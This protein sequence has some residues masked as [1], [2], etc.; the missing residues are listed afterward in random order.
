MH[1]SKLLD[2]KGRAASEF[3]AFVQHNEGLRRGL[4]PA[5]LDIGSLRNVQAPSAGRGSLRGLSAEG[6]ASPTPSI[7]AA[8]GSEAGAEAMESAST[9]SKQGSLAV[10][11]WWEF[12]EDSQGQVLVKPSVRCIKWINAEVDGLGEV[13]VAAE[14]YAVLVLDVPDE[15]RD[16]LLPARVASSLAAI[17]ERVQQSLFSRSGGARP[18]PAGGG[19]APSAVSRA[20]SR[21]ESSFP[22]EEEGSDLVEEAF[23]AVYPET[24]QEVV[25]VKDFRDVTRALYRWDNAAKRLDAL[26]AR[27]GAK[28]PGKGA[29]IEVRLGFL[30]LWG[31]K[32]PAVAYYEQLVE[33][34]AE[35]V[36][37]ARREARRG[38]PSPARFVLFSSQ[39]AAA[40][41]AQSCLMPVDSTRFRVVK[42]P[43][44]DDIYWPS[45]QMGRRE[46]SL[47]Q[48]AVIPIILLIMTLP[49]GIFAG[50]V[51]IFTLALCGGSDAI[52]S[53]IYWPWFCESTSAFNRLIKT[54]LV[55][56]L[57]PLLLTLWQIVVMR[58]LYYV[59]SAEGRCVS[60]SG[61]DRRILKLYF[62][63]D[64]FNLFLGATCGS[65]L[66][67][68]GSQAAR[69]EI[70]EIFAFLGPALNGASNFFVSYVSLRAFTM[71]PFK[72]LYPH[73]AVLFWSVRKLVGKMCCCVGRCDATFRQ[74]FESWAPKSFMY[75][76]E[77]GIFLLI[78]L[79]GIVYAVSTPILPAFCALY[80]L[81][82]W[83]V[84]KHH[85]LYVYSRAYESGGYYYYCLFNRVLI[86]LNT[87][88]IFTS[89]QFFSKQAWVQAVVLIVTGPALVASFQQLLN[90]RVGRVIENMP[91]QIAA[92]MPAG[93]V[94]R[95]LYLPPELRRES[96]G[97]HPESGKAW[98]GYGVP[99]WTL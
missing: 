72:L 70:K 74:Q 91:L 93:R 44:P 2:S 7:L 49:A 94:P 20:L 30:G 60:L 26:R 58:V 85:L 87:M 14:F 83:G 32:V 16:R 57:P 40:T 34:Y 65:S 78:L 75:G 42:A 5:A 46:K 38:P 79:I 97:W 54:V 76:K 17:P 35:E 92:T 51:S 27:Q 80:F 50:A 18:G 21:T 23:Q 67:L 47:R 63:W 77:G 73:P 43:G 68:I 59:A 98:Q 11:K 4:R 48:I 10:Q 52:D 82:A 25:P 3:E 89:I 45:L 90:K 53:D 99:M 24:F 39:V 56:W 95:D 66:F 96:A 88:T 36:K 41:A 6:G 9:L 29:A 12:R 37:R 22:G 33:A 71:V 84:Y 61:L 31:R 8:A 1:P 19:D 28:A 15:D 64:F 13:G 62:Y 86:L 69:L 55:S 81:L